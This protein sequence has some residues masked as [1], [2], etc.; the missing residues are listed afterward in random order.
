MKKYKKQLSIRITEPV[1]KMIEAESD[2]LGISQN[3]VVHMILAKVAERY[4]NGKED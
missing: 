3:L 1:Q 4:H 2:R